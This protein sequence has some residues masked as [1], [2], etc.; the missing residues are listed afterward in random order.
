MIALWLR[1]LAAI[2]WKEFRA[3]LADPRSRF[4]VIGPPII[5]FFV[6][7]YAATFD[8]KHVAYAVLDED[9]SGVARPAGASPRRASPRR[10][11]RRHLGPRRRSTA[12]TRLV[13]RVGPGSQRGSPRARRGCGSARRPQLGRLRHRRRL[14]RDDRLRLEPRGG[15]APRRRAPPARRVVERLVQPDPE[16]R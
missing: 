5:Q 1:Q 8:V 15:S 4:V 3:I 7:G 10:R 13:L 6:F 14:R 2:A 16:S 12:W 9:R 11:A